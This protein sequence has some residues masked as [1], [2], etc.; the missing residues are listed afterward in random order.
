M[1]S[2]MMNSYVLAALAAMTL[3]C[4]SRDAQA[5]EMSVQVLSIRQG[6]NFAPRVMLGH[7]VT[8]R[9]KPPGQT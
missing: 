7:M 9:S 6:S 4:S 1:N 2:R 8:A 5:L 3:L